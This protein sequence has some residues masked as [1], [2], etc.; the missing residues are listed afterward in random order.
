MSEEELEELKK[1]LLDLID[2]TEI[3]DFFARIDKNKNIKYN[4]NKFSSLRNE[5][6]SPKTGFDLAD[7]LKAFVQTIKIK[8]NE[9]IIVTIKNKN[10]NSMQSKLTKVI[11]IGGILGSAIITI[12][13]YYCH[14]IPEHETPKCDTYSVIATIRYE[15]NNQIAKDVKVTVGNIDRKTGTD[16]RIEIP[17][18]LTKGGFLEFFVND[19]KYTKD[20]SGYTIDYK[21]CIINVSDLF[22][23]PVPCSKY[24]ATGTIRYSNNESVKNTNIKVGRIEKPTDVNG[25]VEIPVEL[26]KGGSLEFFVNNKRYVKDTLE[27][28]INYQN[29]TI[30]FELI[31]DSILPPHPSSRIYDI[32]LILNEDMKDGIITVDG[33]PA[34]IKDNTLKIISVKEGTHTITIENE[35]K[36]YSIRN[37]FINKNTELIFD[38]STYKIKN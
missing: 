34:T 1:E 7:R 11:V 18:N 14:R 28:I 17:V 12:L 36:R 38:R 13:A 15:N 20:T 29:C 30:E 6:I 9:D 27:Y 37:Q 31:I 2:R 25:I 32:R 3:P 5:F 35:N 26:T 24:I 22:I 21:N 33:Q 4:K 8:T 10:S 23:P 16:G 19:K